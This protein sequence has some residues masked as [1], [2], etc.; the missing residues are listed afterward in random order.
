MY[1]GSIVRNNNIYNLLY[2]EKHYICIISENNTI[3][4][5][6]LNFLFCIMDSKNLCISPL[7]SMYD[8]NTLS[9]FNTSFMKMFVL[10]LQRGMFKFFNK[11]EL[12]GFAYKIKTDNNL[13]VFKL[14]YSHLVYHNLNFNVVYLGQG[15]RYK[16]NTSYRLASFNNNSLG[17]ELAMIGSYRQVNIYSGYGIRT[18]NKQLILKKGKVS[19]F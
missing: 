12:R 4:K 15:K 11:F 18:Q 2:F 17:D 16:D 19:M 13:L 6:K 10:F 1:K 5:I 3:K 9:Y 14:G 7:I 8:N